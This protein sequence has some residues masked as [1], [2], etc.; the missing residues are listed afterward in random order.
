MVRHIVEGH[1]GEVRVD[2]EPDRGSTFTIVLPP[3]RLA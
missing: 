1:G 3:R 2:S